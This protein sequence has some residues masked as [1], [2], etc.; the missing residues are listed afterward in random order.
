MADL[1]REAIA[2]AKRVKSAA[3]ANAKIALEE[4]FQPTLQRMI[5]AKITEEEGEDEFADDEAGIDI[6]VNYGGDEPDGDEGFGGEEEAGTGFGSF[7]GGEEESPA[8]EGEESGE[9][10]LE[11]EALIRELEGE[12]EM[13]D[14]GEEDAFS[15]PIPDAIEEEDETED[16]TF[17]EGEEMD[18]DE[19]MEAIL[20]ELD[21]DEDELME[22]E[23]GAGAYE[24]N[25]P[26]SQ[27]NTE[28]RKLR[29]QNS[30]LKKDLNESLR[31]LT[32][33]KTTINE[34]NLL[35]A[36]LMYTTKTFRSYPLNENQQVRILESFDRA[37]TVREVKL[38]Y[39][40]IVESFNKK[41]TTKKKVTE[42]LASKSV[43][44]IN[45]KPKNRLDENSDDIVRWSP[46]RLQQLAGLK[47]LND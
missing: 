33:Y 5:S 11:L 10:D 28:V 24:D 41:S 7:E 46:S 4:T 36:K 2:D 45:P 19:M 30:K 1:L 44:A 43:K 38:V 42:G 23:D 47:K 25:A 22:N 27:L 16:F 8:P 26:T 31:A 18:D 40:T 9:E 34:V 37:K 15:D 12:D 20:R 32:T 13:M 35:N 21:G 39:T 29:R 17:S 14:E 6:D 3:L